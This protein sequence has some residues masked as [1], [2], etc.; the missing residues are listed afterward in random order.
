MIEKY[1]KYLEKINEPLQRFF[2]L[3]KPYIHCKKGCSLCCESGDY[4]F[5]K[6]EF[7]YAMIGFNNLEKKEQ[8]FVKNKI[9][10]LKKTKSET[11]KKFLYECPFLIEKQCCIYEHRGLIC[12]NY[13]LPYFTTDDE[14]KPSYKIPFCVS[15]GLNYS[16]VYNEETGTFC[17]K[18]W[19]ET[20]IKVEPVSFNIGREFLLKNEMTE[21]LSLNFGES[22]AIIDWF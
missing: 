16:N 7:K 15:S 21:A 22:R 4:P 1:E 14:N 5:S 9:E 13:G 3:Q 2:A 6:L 12:R 10:K 8:K 17:S 11:N 18:K 20:G 19:K